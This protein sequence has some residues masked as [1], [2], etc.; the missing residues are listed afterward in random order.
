MPIASRRLLL[1]LL[2]AASLVLDAALAVEVIG[3]SQ[4][5]LRTDLFLAVA[6]SQATAIGT[7]VALGS[8]S[9]ANR[10]SIGI[11]AVA[12][13]SALLSQAQR[14]MGDIF[15][16]ASLFVVVL[17]AEAFVMFLVGRPLKLARSAADDT[18]E[19]AAPNR[20]RPQFS[21][22][23][24]FEV[25]AAMGLLIAVLKRSVTIMFAAVP[26]RGTVPPSVSEIL[27]SEAMAGLVAIPVTGF[28]V[29]AAW[30]IWT[31]RGARAAVWMVGLGIVFLIILSGSPTDIL[32]SFVMSFALVICYLTTFRLCGYQIERQPTQKSP[33]V[34]RLG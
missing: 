1:V 14:R 11:C 32:V 4:S 12:A 34:D 7:W 15:F 21:L 2:V 3:D 9:I 24:I 19:P 25:I 33:A 16:M 26:S 20:P 23:A 18:A 22:L 28:A 8:G 10:L 30:A 17:A 6:M 29:F 27:G 5:D 31:F 13:L